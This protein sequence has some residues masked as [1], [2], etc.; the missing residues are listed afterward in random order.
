MNFYGFAMIRNGVKFDYPFKE[1]LLSMKPLVDKVFMAVGKSGDG[2]EE[3]LLSP[4][5]SS[6]L[7][8]TPTVWDD[9][10]TDRGHIFSEQTNIALNELRKNLKNS[11]D[12]QNSFAVYLQSDEV[13]HEDEIPLI[14]EDLKKAAEGGYDAVSFR[15]YHFWQHHNQIAINK[16]W[17]PVEIRAVKIDSSIESYGDAQSFKGQKKIYESE[18]HIYHYGHVRDNKAYQEKMERMIQYYHPE[19]G[20]SHYK[21]KWHKK[22]KKT[23]TIPFFGN[24]PSV[25][26][27]RMARIG[28][29]F[30]VKEETKRNKEIFILAKNHELEEISVVKEKIIAEKVH[31]IKKLSEVPL[32]KRKNVIILRPNFLEKIFFK[33]IVPQQMRSKLAR[34]WALKTLLML[35]LSEKGIGLKK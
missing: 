14:K 12:Y 1:S 20:F 13:F 32:S 29:I 27:E 28:G 18:A 35:K 21:R 2:T 33:S 6:F 4:E 16:K 9:S 31:I 22:D 25:M 26:Q 7:H 10:R 11:P 34:P 8:T 24:H 23:K 3:A 15:Y 30:Q 5:V 17:Y 19:E